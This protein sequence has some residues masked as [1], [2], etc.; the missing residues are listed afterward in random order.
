M[1]LRFYEDKLLVILMLWTFSKDGISLRTS[2]AVGLFSGFLS[3]SLEITTY[4]ELE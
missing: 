4:R 1:L 2:S 3:S